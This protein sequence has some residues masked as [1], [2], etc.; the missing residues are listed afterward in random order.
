MLYF[1]L[2]LCLIGIGLGT[3]FIRS[4]QQHELLQSRFNQIIGLRQLIHL[5]RF[6]R[7]QSPH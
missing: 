4:R 3:I 6:H 5:L 1:I 7:R 2:T